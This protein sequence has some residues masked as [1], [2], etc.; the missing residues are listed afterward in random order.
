M[1]TQKMETIG[2]SP[3]V[4]DYEDYS[5]YMVNRWA[6]KCRPSTTSLARPKIPSGIYASQSSFSSLSGDRLSIAKIN[7]VDLTLTQVDHLK[8]LAA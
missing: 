6:F 1:G 4:A 3:S 2:P 5:R 7:G 8:L